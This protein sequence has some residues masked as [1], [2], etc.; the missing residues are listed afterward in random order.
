M[1]IWSPI[2]I[3]ASILITDLGVLQWNWVLIVVVVLLVVFVGFI[4]CFLVE[5]LHLIDIELDNFSIGFGTFCAEWLPLEWM[6]GPFH[7]ECR[8][9]DL[10]RLDGALDGQMRG[11]RE[12]LEA[13]IFPKD[14]GWII[15]KSMMMNPVI[16]NMIKEREFALGE[17]NKK[18]SLRKRLAPAKVRQRC[19]RRFH[20]Q[21]P[22]IVIRYPRGPGSIETVEVQMKAPSRRERQSLRGLWW[23]FC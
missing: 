10:Q 14:L 12:V 6:T 22:C 23:C 13:R 19:A 21:I 18:M 4:V 3:Y 5:E 8:W 1:G 9:W 11:V 15:V 17:A 2:I 16:R 20:S 7:R